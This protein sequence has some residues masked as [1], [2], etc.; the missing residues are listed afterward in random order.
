MPAFSDDEGSAVV[1]FT[2]VGVNPALD[3]F[4]EVAALM[5]KNSEEAAAGAG[6]SS[7]RARSARAGRSSR[8]PRPRRGAARGSSSGVSTTAASTRSILWPVSFSI[9]AMFSASAGVA[10]V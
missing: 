5:R 7:R 3:E 4:T 10:S 6:A 1:E 2:L 9:S 8:P